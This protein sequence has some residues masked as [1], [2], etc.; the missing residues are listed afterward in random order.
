MPATAEGR[1]TRRQKTLLTLPPVP[2]VILR[3]A[4][5]QALD[6]ADVAVAI[7]GEQLPV[8]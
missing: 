4:L 6:P 3:P 8:G 7:D 2:E 1:S 5:D